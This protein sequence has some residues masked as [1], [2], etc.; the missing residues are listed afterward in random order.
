MKNIPY[1]GY[2]M[3]PAGGLDAAVDLAEK[4]G[5]HVVLQ[6]SPR[7]MRYGS[8]P[9]YLCSPDRRVMTC[10]FDRHGVLSIT[11]ESEYHPKI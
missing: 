6:G 2:I 8:N 4:T 5:E 1:A 9:H 7:T 10:S 3:P 11:G